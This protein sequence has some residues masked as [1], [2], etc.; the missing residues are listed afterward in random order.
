MRRFLSS[1]GDAGSRRVSPFSAVDEYYRNHDCSGVAGTKTRRREHYLNPHIKCRSAFRGEQY[2][3]LAHPLH[4]FRQ[5]RFV[6]AQA[7]VLSCH[8]RQQDSELTGLFPHDLEYPEDRLHELL[9]SVESILR[10][11]AR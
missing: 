2:V 8:V 6:R 7:A 1:T 5:L 3:G 9:Q 11:Q 10:H 4:D